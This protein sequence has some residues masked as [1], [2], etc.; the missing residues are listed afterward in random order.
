MFLAKAE[1]VARGEMNVDFI[2]QVNARQ[3]RPLAAV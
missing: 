1:Q 2:F 3:P